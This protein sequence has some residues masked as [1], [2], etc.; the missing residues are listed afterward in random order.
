[1]GDHTESFDVMVRYKKPNEDQAVEIKQSVTDQGLDY[2]RASD[3]LKLSSAVAG[4]GLLLRNSPSKGNLTYDAVLELAN[5]T[6]GFDPFGERKEFIEMVR[7]AKNLV[8]VPVM[9]APV[10]P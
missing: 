2:S 3:D 5:P 6:L 10:A 4:F 9:A 1:A 7:K 8:V